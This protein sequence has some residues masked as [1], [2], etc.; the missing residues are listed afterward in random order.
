MELINKEELRQRLYDNV[1]CGYET[2]WDG[3]R[4]WVRYKAVE[5]EIESCSIVDERAKAKWGS[6]I[7]Q[8]SWLVIETYQCTRCGGEPPFEKDISKYKYCPYCGARME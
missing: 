5:D 8:D 7:K 3:G 2:L 1:Y 4:C 6:L